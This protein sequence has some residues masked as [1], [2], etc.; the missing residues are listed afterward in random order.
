MGGKGSGPRPQAEPIMERQ[1]ALYLLP[2]D[3]VR[4]LAACE[5]AGLLPSQGLRAAV[6]SWVRLREAGLRRRKGRG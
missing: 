5:H 4:F 6:L 1:Q 2:D 3:A